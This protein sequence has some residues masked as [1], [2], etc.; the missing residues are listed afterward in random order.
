VGELPPF[1][2]VAVKVTLVPLQ[3]VLTDELIVM[4]GVREELTVMVM[5]FDVAVEGLAQL[6]LLVKTQLTTSL[7]ESELLV[8]VLELVP[9]LLPFTFHWY[10]G[11]VPPPLGVA[12]KVTALPV[13]TVV[14]GVLITIDGLNELA[15]VIRISF[16]VAGPPH[17][18]VEL[19]MHFTSSPL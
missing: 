8:K 9:A 18:P 15:S 14:C 12:V 11:F 4:E 1:V 3:A 17:E 2:A 5:L 7:F 16:E 10:D 6:A 19:T 13:H